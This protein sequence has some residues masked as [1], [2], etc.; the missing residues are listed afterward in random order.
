[1]HAG[2][3][4]IT[5]NEDRQH[6]YVVLI[7]GTGVNMAFVFI[8]DSPA[9]ERSLTLLIRDDGQRATRPSDSACRH[10]RAWPD[11]PATDRYA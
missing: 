5:G 2:L 11:R 6:A 1:V 7:R 10:E 9:T 8:G 3:A 4:V